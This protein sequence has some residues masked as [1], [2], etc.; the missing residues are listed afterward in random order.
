MIYC[1]TDQEIEKIRV[2]CGWVCKTLALVASHL[3]PGISGAQVDKI[4]EEH[5]LDNGVKPGFKGYQGFPA[6]LCISVNEQVVHGIPSKEPFKNGDIVSIDC[7]SYIDEFFGDAAFTF[8]L[9][10]TDDAIM[11]LL[12]TTRHA[13]ALGIEKAKAGNR[14]GDIGYAIQEFCERQK[15]YGVVRELVGHGIGKNLHEAPEVPNFGRRG[16][17]TKLQEGMVIAIEP[18][19]NLGTRKVKHHEDGW[20]IKAADGSISAHYE[21]TVAVR[22]D[23]ADILSNHQIIEEQ[24]KLNPNLMSVPAS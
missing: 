19:V 23:G 9:G 11:K 8:V 24:I 15:G 5:L 22:K 12:T 17:G 13:L 7:G 20:T 6:T 4:A 2:A 1:K 18:M 14:I 16:N 21:H 10:E 3:K